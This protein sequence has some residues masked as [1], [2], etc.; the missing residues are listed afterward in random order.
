[1]IQVGRGRPSRVTVCANSV[2]AR[3]IVQ[4]VWPCR[5]AAGVLPFLYSSSY[6][7]YYSVLTSCYAKLPNLSRTNPPSLFYCITHTEHTLC[8]AVRLLRYTIKLQWG[9]GAGKFW[10]L[11]LLHAHALLAYICT[12]VIVCG[13]WVRRIL[14]GC[15]F[16]FSP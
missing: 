3:K 9:T 7:L 6:L 12:H 14:S 2:V 4:H 10:L 15:R 16:L 13:A 11:T 8:T 1:M 5:F